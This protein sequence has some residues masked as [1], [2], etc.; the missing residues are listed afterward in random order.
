MIGIF[1]LIILTVI[2][3]AIYHVLQRFFR[4]LAPG[5]QNRPP[6]NRSTQNAKK[7]SAKDGAVDADFEELD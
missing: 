6:Q 3:Y 7:Y 5:R 1:R 2:A 4:A